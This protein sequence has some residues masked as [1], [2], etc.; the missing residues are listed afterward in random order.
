MSTAVCNHNG[1]FEG[2]LHISIESFLNFLLAFL[3][4]S[5][6]RISNANVP[7]CQLWKNCKKCKRS[8]INYME[9]FR[10]HIQFWRKKVGLE[11]VIFLQRIVRSIA[12]KKTFQRNYL[13]KIW[14]T[15]CE[16]FADFVSYRYRNLRSTNFA[17][18]SLPF[19]GLNKYLN[20]YQLSFNTCRN[21]VTNFQNAKSNEL[22]Q[23]P[24]FGVLDEINESISLKITCTH[25]ENL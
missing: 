6:S 21:L 13:I 7:F 19:F 18:R 11:L 20:M 15:I 2:D 5:Y 12:L 14:L 1:Y 24:Y 22:Y 4:P 25:A 3:C 17:F 16:Q 9:D 10:I 23:L 8:K